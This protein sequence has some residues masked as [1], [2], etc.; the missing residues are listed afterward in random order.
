MDCLNLEYSN[1]NFSNLNFSNLEYLNVEYLNL[2]YMN[3]EYYIY[4]Y[5]KLFLWFVYNPSGKP[6]VS[7][8]HGIVMGGGVGISMNGNYRIATETTTFAMPEVLLS[9]CIF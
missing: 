4:E 9:S 5:L 3:L 6:I 8:I 2:K 7:L 1:L